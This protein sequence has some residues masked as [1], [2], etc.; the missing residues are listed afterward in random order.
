MMRPLS[1]LLSPPE[2]NSINFPLTTR[3]PNSRKSPNQFDC[4]HSAGQLSAAERTPN[5]AGG[6]FSYTH[7]FPAGRS[8]S[9]ACGILWSHHLYAKVR[10][11]QRAQTKPVAV[12]CARR[13]SES[14]ARCSAL[15]RPGG[16]HPVGILICRD[17]QDVGINFTRRRRRRRRPNTHTHADWLAAHTNSA[18]AAGGAA[19]PLNEWRAYIVTHS[20]AHTHT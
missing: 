20:R 10:F 13:E 18:A 1:K 7:L 9:V 3:G 6:V 19:E 11:A 14:S 8:K 2:T 5:S 17:H 4:G 15:T 16:V 12:I